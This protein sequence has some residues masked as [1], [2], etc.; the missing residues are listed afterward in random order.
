MGLQPLEIAAKLRRDDLDEALALGLAD[1]LS[2][3]CCSYQC[4]ASLPLVELFQWGKQQLA[5]QRYADQKAERTKQSREQRTQRL[6]REAEAKKAAK[7]G[8]RRARRPDSKAS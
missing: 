4:A 5:L 1:C 3:G 2:C 6:A 8:K 7:A